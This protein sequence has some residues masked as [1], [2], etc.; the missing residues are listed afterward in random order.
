MRQ[1]QQ[2]VRIT[3]Q[4][5]RDNPRLFTT[6]VEDNHLP[7]PRVFAT[8]GEEENRR[9]TRSMALPT[10]P[11]PRVYP[12]VMS[13]PT[14]SFLSPL[15]KRAKRRAS[16]QLTVASDTPARNTRSCTTV[17]ARH[18][19]PIST[20]TQACTRAQTRQHRSQTPTPTRATTT[21]W[22]DSMAMAVKNKS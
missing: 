6:N 1:L 5:A 2:L 14:P 8:N 10:Q 7:V 19:A 16:L 22:S 9:I 12:P 11:L 13:G 18:A 20:G 3:T 4:A 15:R 17:A 21:H